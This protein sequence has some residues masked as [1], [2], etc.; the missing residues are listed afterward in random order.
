MLGIKNIVI[1]DVLMSQCSWSLK[2]ED[3]GPA[4]SQSRLS[5]VYPL[6]R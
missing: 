4:G 6:I 5:T 2:D 1:F 3:K